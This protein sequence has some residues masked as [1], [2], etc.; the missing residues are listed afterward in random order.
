MSSVSANLIKA[1]IKVESGGKIGAVGDGGLAVG[2]LQIHPIVIDD[3]NRIY[4]T[5]FTLKDRLDPEKSK[6]ICRLYLDYYGRQYAKKT[7]LKPTDEVLSRIWNG[8]PGGWKKQ[9]TVKYWNK[10]KAYYGKDN[11]CN[12]GG[13][14]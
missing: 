12:S 9:S 10:V 3:V 1:L 5:K 2:V 4:K 7:G 14:G 11:K 8:G 13:N 6:T